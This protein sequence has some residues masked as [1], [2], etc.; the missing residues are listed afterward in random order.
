MTLSN[1]NSYSPQLS[2]NQLHEYLYHSIPN[3]LNYSG[4][5]NIIYL[6]YLQLSTSIINFRIISNNIKITLNSLMNNPDM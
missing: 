3:S 1:C 4:P 6:K 2:L 5:D